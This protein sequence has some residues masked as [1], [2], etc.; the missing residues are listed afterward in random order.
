[1]R[2][3]IV[4]ISVFIISSFIYSQNDL[5]YTKVD[6]LDVLLKT[7]QKLRTEN[8]MYEALE[9]AFKAVTYAQNLNHNHYLSHAYFAM[10]TIQY[11]IIDYENAKAHMLKALEYSEKTD[12]KK[13]LP[14]IL[15]GLANIYYD[16]NG[17]YEN[18]L[19]YYKKG[20]E[21]A[22]N[23]VH[24]NNYQIPLNNLIW[25]YMD[26][27]KF[28]EAAPYLKEADSIDKL[29]PD[30]IQLGRT[31][32]YLMR[33]RNYAHHGDIESAKENFE[34]TFKLLEEEEKYWL[35]GKSYFYQYR[36]E[37]YQDI[38]DYPNALK[39][40]KELQKNERKV[41]E[42]ARVKDQEITKI[43]FKVDEYE[44]ELEAAQREKLLL[45][46]IDK[47]NK[48]IIYI[49]LICLLLL[50]GTVFFYY[51]G[52]QSK[53]KS[54]ETL[55]LKNIE[56]NKAKSAAE[57]LSK[58]KSQFISTISHELRTPLYGVI[59]ISSLLLENNKGSKNDKELLSS[60]KFSADYLLNLVNKVLKI[61]KIDSKKTELVQTPTS[62]LS[63][64]KNILRSFEYQS[65]EKQNELLLEYNN[66]I[67][68]LVHIDSLWV[69]EILINLIGNA[70]KFTEKGKIWLRVILK[71]IDTKKVRIQFE[72]EDTGIGIPE[73]QKEY[74]FEEFSQVGSVY[75]NKQG[76][77]LGL[78]IV[79]NLLQRMDSKIHFESNKNIGS[80]FYFVLNLRI[81]D[82]L[83]AVSGDANDSEIT[84]SLGFKILI[85]EDNK[86]NQL[87]TKNLL[88]S[89]GCSCCIAENGSEALQLLKE[90][91]FD[92]VLMDINMP[93]LD[94]LTATK[95]IREFDQSTPII[96]LTASELSE[97]EDECLDAGMND[98]VNK[99]LNKVDLK[100]A[101]L[102][103]LKLNNHHIK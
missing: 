16:D 14:Y 94:G 67:P 82:Q 51:R 27:G 45:L 75:D 61:S 95:K 13:L 62:L 31:S 96:A 57:K 35:K 56:L 92:L 40:L 79:K 15:Q 89:I 87:V 48:V 10:G 76:T 86:I 50:I 91:P 9:L 8:N 64:S 37:M 70:I 55:R 83:N 102:K 66:N 101:I 21:L 65:K 33:A 23:K 6:S 77:G 88:K 98:L 72:V 74:I 29:I 12:S 78:S 34:K 11:E 47:N 58:I 39:D 85:A 38:K 53:K 25:T 100:E 69:S 90:Q 18:A 5:G 4:F 80:K 81:C 22:K 19:I 24:I 42:N 103:N 17:D 46:N 99:P 43:R 60:L 36:A 2:K 28:D 97:V 1:M 49:S 32:L 59:G 20:V 63:L 26:L 68:N 3:N 93:I 44:R 7:S 52:Y 73:D 84:T 30:S 71:Y 41:F 54:S